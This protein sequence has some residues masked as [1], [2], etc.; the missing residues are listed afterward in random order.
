MYVCMYV[1]QERNALVVVR[2]VHPLSNSDNKYTEY[3]V[4]LCVSRNPRKHVR[5]CHNNFTL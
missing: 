2:Y 3:L 1:E 4:A 5:I